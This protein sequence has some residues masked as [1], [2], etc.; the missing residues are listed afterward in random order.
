[1]M[2]MW[3][4]LSEWKQRTKIVEAEGEGEGERLLLMMMKWFLLW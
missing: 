4:A 1:M 2:M 3:A